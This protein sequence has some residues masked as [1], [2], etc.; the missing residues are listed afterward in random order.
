MSTATTEKE[1]IK[2][3][4]SGDYEF[5]PYGEF[6]SYYH[7]HLQLFN[8][9]IG[10]KDLSN[11]EKDEL[12]NRIKGFMVAN[13]K[14][15]DHF[16]ERIDEFATFLSMDKNKLSNYLSDNFLEILTK[17]QNVLKEQELEK[18]NKSF[19]S[20]DF[21]RVT[22]EIIYM[23]GDIFPKNSRFTKREGLLVIEDMPSGTISK[24]VGKLKEMHEDK[25]KLEREKE[26]KAYRKE[27]K[28]AEIA[29]EKSILLEILEQLGDD[30][31]GEKLEVK[32]HNYEDFKVEKV[33]DEKDLRPKSILDGVEDLQLETD[34]D[35]EGDDGSGYS[36]DNDYGEDESE[37]DSEDIDLEDILGNV[38]TE[39]EEDEADKF[40][41][42]EYNKLK[43]HIQT[44]RSNNDK[45]GYNEW[46]SSAN[47]IEK[48]YI[49]INTNLQKENK[50][51]TIDWDHH[52]RLISQKTSLNE[53]T[54][55]KLKSR[56]QHF[57]ILKGVFDGM[58][59][60][61][62]TKQ[63]EIIALSRSAWPHVMNIFDDSPN[64]ETVED[65]IKQLLS[66]VKNEEHREALEEVI[67][68]GVDKLREDFY[69]I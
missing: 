60:K 58:V 68:G 28:Q 37:E 31:K 42:K 52:F 56:I 8:Q 34:I 9:L 26:E 55:S 4:P 50:G 21:N 48:S 39:E 66:R 45:D 51:D 25:V 43:N 5:T 41:Y 3:S 12:Y 61:I 1:I 36:D 20:N 44:F 64:Y 63:P 69:S 19:S 22:D 53:A 16:F 13:I 23:I 29:Y 54:L 18:I 11:N 62:K 46:L 10:T 35:F 2:R 15:T 40:N 65:N 17:V 47:D 7:A 38:D 59:K 6:L 24:P 67:L 49:S 27:R 14:K 57:Q 32:Q 33:I 30:L